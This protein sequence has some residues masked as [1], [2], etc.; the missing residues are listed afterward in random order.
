IV[1]LF[2]AFPPPLIAALAGL[3]LIGAIASN[4]ELLAQ[5]RGTLEASVIAF[6]AT[7]SG[8]SLFGLGAAFWGVVLGMA[9]HLMLR[10]R[11]T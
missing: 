5:E 3:A 8:M 4:L 10:P 9:S 11:V 2:N 6:L 7:A 1:L